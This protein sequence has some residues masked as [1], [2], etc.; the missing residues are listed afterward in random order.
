M[1]VRLLI[2]VVRIMIVRILFCFSKVIVLLFWV[3]VLCFFRVF[4]VI[5]NCMR[6]CLCRLLFL[7]VMM[8]LVL[9]MF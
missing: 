1:R 4:G 5:I 8:M 6:Y 2:E 9:M 7:G 3:V